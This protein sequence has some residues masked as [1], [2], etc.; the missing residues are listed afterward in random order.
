MGGMG[1]GGGVHDKS[2]FLRFFKYLCGIGF[3][4][5]SPSAFHTAG[6]LNNGILFKVA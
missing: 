6:K 1:G 5:S 4:L 2:I 3:S